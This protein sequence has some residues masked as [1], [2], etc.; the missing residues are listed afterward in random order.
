MNATAHEMEVIERI[1][2]RAAVMASKFG[3]NTRAG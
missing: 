1:V 2:N 3:S